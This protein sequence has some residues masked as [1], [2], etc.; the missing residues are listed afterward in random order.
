MKTQHWS[1]TWSSGVRPGPGGWGDSGEKGSFSPWFRKGLLSAGS[2]KK[3]PAH[4][5]W[6]IWDNTDTF[7]QKVSRLGGL[8]R[9]F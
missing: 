9:D 1:R 2:G 4:K 7:M 8:E 3:I 5:E 6:L